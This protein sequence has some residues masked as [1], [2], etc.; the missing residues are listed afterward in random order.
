MAFAPVFRPIAAARHLPALS[1]P[2]PPRAASDC[3]TPAKLRKSGKGSGHGWRKEQWQ[4][5]VAQKLEKGEINLNKRS[6][7]QPPETKESKKDDK[8]RDD[9]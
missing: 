3:P 5:K 9:F 7:D 4:V 1:L 2:T 6:D 8:D